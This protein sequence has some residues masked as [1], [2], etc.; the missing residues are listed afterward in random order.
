[1][2]WFSGLAFLRPVHVA[3]TRRVAR[4]V[5]TLLAPKYRPMARPLLFNSFIALLGRSFHLCLPDSQPST[6]GLERRPSLAS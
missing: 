1:M 2:L 6:G 5:L 4:L 3:F